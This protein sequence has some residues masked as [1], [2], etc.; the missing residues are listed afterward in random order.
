M[1]PIRPSFKLW[2][3]AS[4]MCCGLAGVPQHLPAQDVTVIRAGRLVDVVQGIVRQDQVIVIRGERI[5][6]VQ[7]ASAPLPRGA[8]GARG[9]RVIDLSRYT[10]LPGLIDC[11]THLVGNLQSASSTA[12][13]ER[14]GAQ[15][16]LAGVRHAR[17]TLLAGFT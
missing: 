4:L 12:P 11:H 17:E 10:V 7:A 1:T 15:D 5:E 13:L 3:T 2:R 9:A 16:V 14:S 8:R 6:S